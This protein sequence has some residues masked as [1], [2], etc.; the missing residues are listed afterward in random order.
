MITV[1]ISNQKGGVSKTTTAINVADAL[2]HIGY[3]VLFIDMDP[4]CNSTGT[5]NA[6][7]DDTY[8][9]VNV[10]KRDCK[11]ADA[12]QHTSLGDIIAG[13]DILIQE[14]SYFQ[15]RTA[16]EYLLKDALKEVEDDYD[17][18][19]IDTPPNLG[20]YMINSLTAADGCIVPIRAEEYSLKG[21]G[22]LIDTINDIVGHVNPGLKIYGVLLTAYDMRNE[23]DRDVWNQ[24]PDAGERLNFNVFETPIRINQAVKKVQHKKLEN[25]DD[26]RSLYDNYPD[27]NAAHDYAQVV[28]ALLKEVL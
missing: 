5:Y 25:E 12:I 23:L 3:R 28:K 27:C 19:V 24:L 1:A 10:L 11:T 20:V 18:V 9:I 14:E 7:I 17:F 15:S 13:D 2:K 22:L 16:R 6:A 21:L 8:T 4:Q 26:N